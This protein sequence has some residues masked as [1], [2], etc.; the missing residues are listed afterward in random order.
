MVLLIA[1]KIGRIKIDD[2][3]CHLSTYDK[4]Y[5]SRSKKANYFN[6]YAYLNYL[7]KIYFYSY[8]MSKMY[9]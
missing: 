7:M 6:Y 5:I 3:K 2:L 1:S 8:V 9:L 4:T